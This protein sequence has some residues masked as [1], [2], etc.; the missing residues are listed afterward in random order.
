[1]QR[2]ISLRSAIASRQTGLGDAALT[3]SAPL[4]M[5]GVNVKG[6]ALIPDTMAFLLNPKN[7]IFGVQRRISIAMENEIRERAVVIVM[8]LRIDH[9]YEEEDMVVK[10]TMIGAD[11]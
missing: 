3:S 11:A 10:A 4:N 2:E 6:A 9:K 5:L 7:I 1:M 8:T